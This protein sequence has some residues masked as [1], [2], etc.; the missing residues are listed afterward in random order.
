MRSVPA[1]ALAH[2]TPRGAPQVWAV[3]LAALLSGALFLSLA[4]DAPR[5]A[6]LFLIGIAL[7]VTLYH[8]AFGFTSA[9]RRALTRRDV[10]GVLAQLLMI[11]L[12]MALFAPLLA[13]GAV[14]GQPV[15]GAVAPVGLQVAFGSFLFGLGMQLGGGCGSGT[16][17]T[18]GGGNLRMLVTLVAFCAGAFAGSLDM[19]RYADWPSFGSISLAAEL[20]TVPA[21]ALQASL[22]G[23]IWLGM[24]AWAGTRPQQPLW[25]GLDRTTLLRGP[26]P[27]LFAALLLA[28]LNAVTLILAGHPWT[29]TW[30]F[31][32]WGA[33]ASQAL[34]WDPAG[35]TFWASGFPAM[36]L[37]AGVLEDTTTIMDLG[38]VLGAFTAA[39]LAG[40][41]A[42]RA[43]VPLA[44]LAAAILGGLL[45]GYGARLAFG[46]NIGAFFSG[47][48][49]FSLHGWLWMVC[50]L[51]GTAVGVRL[52]PL[53]GLAD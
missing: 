47:V 29:I 25:S 20:G 33:E 40:R 32:L 53:F 14:L 28:V 45:M 36:A 7:G 19:G 17:F 4:G 6:A 42:P 22:L 15:G 30:A 16:L 38:I 34:G 2:A 1:D 35:S 50:A 9:W 48:A 46:C 18:A 51:A 8:T 26:W 44:S 37:D 39:A 27:L 49:S 23:L 13:S 10:S 21:L 3:A 5:R 12:A 43:K 41:F 11:G 31:T 24:K 52:R